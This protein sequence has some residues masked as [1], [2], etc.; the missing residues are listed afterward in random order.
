MDDLHGNSLVDVHSY[1]GGGERERERD[2]RCA[3]FTAAEP[4][5]R[6]LFLGWSA[7]RILVSRT[8]Q[9]NFSLEA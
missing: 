4:P 5:E 7:F 9:S 3:H 1:G 8:F 6:L 2:W